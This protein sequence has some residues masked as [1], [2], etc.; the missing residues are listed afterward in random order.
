MISAHEIEEAQQLLRNPLWRI[1]NLYSVIDKEGK[2]CQFKLNW[3]QEDLYRNMWYCNIIL[4]AR[5]L[6]ISTL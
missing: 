6:G 4:K 5:Q 3:A 1:N 2:K